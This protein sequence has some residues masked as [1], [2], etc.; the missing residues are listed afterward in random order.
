MPEYPDETVSYKELL[1]I[2][3]KWNEEF[4]KVIGDGLVEID[5]DELLNGV[6]LD[7][8][9][10]IRRA[11]DEPGRAVRLFYSYSH[12]DESFRDELQTHLKLLQRQGFLETWHD[13]KIGAGDDWK[14]SIDDNL[15]RADIIL[16]LVSADFIA[17]DYCYEEE[18]K[19]SLKRHD[20]GEARCGPD[21]RA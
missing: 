1:V 21:H 15:K 12:K 8:T 4:P 2:E 18:M 19:V 14:Q 17:S 9:R 13:R 11:I 5:V 10:R 20:G 6:D 7:N 3:Q 16:L